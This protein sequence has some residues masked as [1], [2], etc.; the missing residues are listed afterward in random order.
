M[1][2]I[3]LDT[4][5]LLSDFYHRYPEFGSIRNPYPESQ[6]K[7]RRLR[8]KIH[9]NL[10]KMSLEPDVMVCTCVP[11]LARMGS[12]LSEWKVPGELVREEISYWISQISVLEVK[13]RHL[14]ATLDELSLPGNQE[15]S[16]D[17]MLNRLV[18]M[19]NGIGEIFRIE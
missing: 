10:L 13:P 12:V 4:H 3:F 11:A 5:I 14:E 9:E 8:E 1:R 6:E 16:F 18:C 15:I 19:E 7:L 17:E 2:K